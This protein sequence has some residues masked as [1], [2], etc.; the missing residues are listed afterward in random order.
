MCGIAGFIGRVRLPGERLEAAGRAL[1]HRGP[2]AV[3][4]RRITTPDGGFC[5]LV[6]TRLA[7]IDLDG[8]ANQPF[9]LDEGPGHRWGPG[10]GTWLAF[11]GELYDHLELRGELEEEGE[12]FAT[13]SDT[14][15]LLRALTRWGT[16]ALDRMEGMWAFALYDG[17]DGA[18]TLC[19]DR[20][21]EKPLFLHRAPEGLYFASE[22]KG[23]FALLG[24]RLP[25]DR[26]QL[27][28]FLVYGYK[29]LHRGTSTFHE[30][31]REL[32]AGT[33]LRVDAQGDERPRRYWTP[34]LAPEPDM[35][36]DE[37]V[38]LVRAR[39]VRSMELRLRADVP[40]AFCMSGG[41]D[42]V[43]LISAAAHELGHD[44][45]G[46]TIVNT[47]ARYEEA[48]MI[49]VAVEHLGVRHTEVRL[50]TDGFLPSLRRQVAEHDG[51]VA[52][53]TWYA[54]RLLVEAIAE[55]GHRVSVSGTGADELF[56][57]YYDHHLAYLAA[58]RDLPE[59]WGP[60]VAAWD[61]H[62]RPLVR[63]PHLSDPEL[64]VRDPGFRDHITLGAR[65]FA[66]R[67]REPFAEPF[68]EAAYEGA[69]LLRTRMLNELFHEAVPVILA[70]DDL[71]AMAV[72]VENRSPFL[73]RRLAELTW[74]IPT[75]HLVRD[76]R[77]KA[78]L[79]DAM[80]GIA[81]Q[82]ILDNRRKVGFNAPLEDLLDLDDPAV[83]R[84]LL[85][86]SPLWDLVRREAVAGLLERRDLPN[87][88]SK[89]L[90]AVLGAKLFLEGCA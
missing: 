6:H 59:V 35:A 74:T 70:E 11:N 33:L 16:R 57:G 62:V 42:S 72:S 88:E 64:F 31:L 12:R 69:D 15:V 78:V 21:G 71:N 49:A 27:A 39:L 5:D 44:V 28:R 61:R 65:E 25:P 1:R 89:F 48:D 26:A 81:P 80:R 46:F 2:D 18:L 86:D 20:F 54:H 67:L 51:P 87:S 60:A 45:H 4:I 13:T 38:A 40:L 52:T 76:G 9:G 79:R 56:T 29:S 85:A 75:R 63:N 23:V 83:R 82:P 22:P 30:G 10:E 36:Y 47:D 17:T 3:G 90:F 8:R 77:A 84:E 24:R 41:V 34:R 32:P 37:A 7:I 43:S 58:V 73:D 19:R 50:S 14:E 68:T 55:T 53:V 66:A